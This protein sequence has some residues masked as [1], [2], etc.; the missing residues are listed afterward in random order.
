MPSVARV[1]LFMEEIHAFPEI[2]ITLC[3]TAKGKR[4]TQLQMKKGD[5]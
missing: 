4:K 3:K 5:I 2:Q 1:L